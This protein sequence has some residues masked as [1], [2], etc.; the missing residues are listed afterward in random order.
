M[1]IYL[2]RHGQCDSNK[3]KIYNVKHEE[4]NEEGIRQARNFKEK[5][6]KQNVSLLQNS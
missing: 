2:V 6:K 5:N 1:K 3:K 4:L